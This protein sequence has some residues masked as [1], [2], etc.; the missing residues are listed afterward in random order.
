MSIK[1]KEETREVETST[2]SSCSTENSKEQVH[3][4]AENKE[5]KQLNQP[6]KKNQGSCCG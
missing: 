5:A 1:E 4:Q 2:A 6:V 3:G